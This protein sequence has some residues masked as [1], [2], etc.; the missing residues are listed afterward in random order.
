MKYY[1]APCLFAA[2]MLGSCSLMKKQIL[3]DDLVDQKARID[4]TV[5]PAMKYEI[6]QDLLKRRIE[7]SGLVVK[8]V[9]LSTNID[10]DFCIVVDLQT[11]KGM[12]EFYIYSADTKTISELVIGKSRIDVSGDF[13]KFFSLLND[14]YT[15]IEIVNASIKVKG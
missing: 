8:D 15:M 11:S 5:N 12:I 4:A 13:G 14:Y 6:N 1:V 2:L 9:V 10:Y 7:L 3:I